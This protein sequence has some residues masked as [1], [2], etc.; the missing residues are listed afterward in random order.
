MHALDHLMEEQGYLYTNQRKPMTQLREGEDWCDN[1][2]LETAAALELYQRGKIRAVLPLLVGK[3]SFFSDANDAFGGV[4]ALPT[5]ASA[6]TMEQV[7]THLQD[8]T[9]DAS[10]TGLR[11]LLQQASGRNEPTVSAVVN[12][13][14][15][16]QGIKVSQAGAGSTHSHGHMSVGMD[17]LSECVSRV[18]AAVSASLKRVG[19]EEV[20]ALEGESPPATKQTMLGRLSSRLAATV[21]SP[22][23]AGGGDEWESGGAVEV[24][25]G[26]GD[27]AGGGLYLSSD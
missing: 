18:H 27:E 16:F 11:E 19:M 10:I 23:V 12:A 25:F 1:V 2:L 14:L 8:T 22:S 7:A 13:L 21:S 3:E 26:G 6:A 24:Q 5:H 17:D 9:G 15:K 20:V 4:A